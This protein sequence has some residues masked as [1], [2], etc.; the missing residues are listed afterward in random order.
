MV[1]VASNGTSGKSGSHARGGGNGKGGGFSRSRD[2]AE[3]KGAELGVGEEM[4]AVGGEISELVRVIGRANKFPVGG[5]KG[6]KVGKGTDRFGVGRGN[7][8]GRIGGF[9]FVK[10]ATAG[11]FGGGRWGSLWERKAELNG[12]H[13]EGD[14]R[15]D[16]SWVDGGT[17]SEI[18][19]IAGA[20]LEVGGDRRS[21]RVAVAVAKT[22]A[23][24]VVNMKE[25][26]TDE[27]ANVVGF[28]SGVVSAPRDVRKGGNELGRTVVRGVRKKKVGK[29]VEA[30]GLEISSFVHGRNG[31]HQ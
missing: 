15:V 31:R 20:G 22:K 21:D 10:K 8:V 24:E 6:M 17:E 19:N 3:S 7:F 18:V 9:I 13:G 30:T 23:S 26:R 4:V 28:Q 14:T 29:V 2:G 27:G 16:G 12:E 11:G 25:S 5:G 1:G